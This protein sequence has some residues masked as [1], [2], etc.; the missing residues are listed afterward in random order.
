ML[1]A[2]A[3]ASAPGQQF[4]RHAGLPALYAL[5]G[6]VP[7]PPGALVVSLDR[8]ATEW[9]RLHA[10]DYARVS[11]RLP[12]CL[13]SDDL[14]RL[15]DLRSFHDM[16]RAIHACLLEALAERGARLVVFD[17]LFNAPRPDDETFERALRK[18][19]EA[20][21]FE[22]IRPLANPG[23]LGQMEAGVPAFLERAHPVP[24]LAD[25]AAGTGTFLVRTPA[26]G[27]VD[28]YLRRVPGYPNLPSLPELAALKVGAAPPLRAGGTSEHRHFWLYGPAHTVPTYTLRDLFAAVP[29]EALPADLSGTTVFVGVSDPA[30]SGGNDHFRVPIGRGPIVHMGG[31]EL[32]ATAFLNLTAGDRLDRPSVLAG[33][34]A[35]GL[36]GALAAFFLLR[37]PGMGALRR[38]GV[39][40][41]VAIGGSVALFAYG[42]VWMPFA[43]PFFLGLPV[44]AV[45]AF[46]WRYAHVRGL[47]R[48]LGPAPLTERV[49]EEADGTMPDYVEEPGTVI[50]ADVVGSTSL[51]ESLSGL[52]FTRLLNDFYNRV[53]PPVEREGGLVLG[54][55]GDSVVAVFPESLCG[56]RHAARAVAATRALC[57]AMDNEP[58]SDPRAGLPPTAL[59]LRIGM[60]TG[61]VVLGRMGARHRFNFQVLG[62]TTNTAARLQSIQRSHPP[63]EGHLV[64]L[65]SEVAAAAGI[66]GD[67]AEVETIG[68]ERLRGKTT[69]L[70]VLRLRLGWPR[71]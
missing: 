68:L 49:L 62:D 11:D 52:A 18:G 43:V 21:L 48:G 42:Q 46:A 57:A 2:L 67:P 69:P 16:P 35:T 50:F 58:F 54:F 59:R 7:A 10:A 31:V 39:L 4:E 37:A 45:A 60:H 30:Y 22:R 6:P 17:I 8:R 71:R 13:V 28:G 5:R 64:L 53:T 41:L 63:G 47:V 70:H 29:G 55:P 66:A 36:Y 3:F 32:A 51:G 61:P 19:P 65:T 26:G 38:A 20:L 15:A 33:A 1:F 40:S 27:M 12:R 14:Q 56:P 44:L 9:L 25:A 24:A 23:P 34:V